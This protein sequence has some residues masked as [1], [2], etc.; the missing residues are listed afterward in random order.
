M[1]LHRRY[2][3]RLKSNSYFILFS[4]FPSLP[5]RPLKSFTINRKEREEG[6]EEEGGG[7]RRSLEAGKGGAEALVESFFSNGLE[8]LSS[9]LDQ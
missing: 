2:L 9:A 8:P 1:L 6:M 4:P 7:E 5:L 3:L